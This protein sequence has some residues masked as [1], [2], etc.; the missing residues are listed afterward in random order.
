[1]TF[2]LFHIKSQH[3][4]NVR[5]LTRIVGWLLIIE[6]I[7]MAIPA[8]TSYLYCESDWMPF[9]LTSSGTTLIGLL[10][11]FR[12]KPTSSHTGKREGF[13]LTASVW[14][15]FSLFGMIPFLF[16]SN[17]L[18][19][20]DAFF[21][22]MSGFTTTG[23]SVITG[24]GSMSHGIHLWRAMMQWIGGMG[25][26][27]FT[28]AIIPMLNHAG[29]MQ[30]FNAE[31]TGITHDKIRPRISQT[32]KSL[33]I[34]Y[35]L[36][37][38]TLVLLLWAGP[39]SLFDSVCH[40]FGTISTGGYSSSPEGIGHWHGSVYVKLVLTGFMFLGGVNF[41]LIFKTAHGDFKA[42][43]Q[44]DVFH[45]YVAMI[46]V[47]LTL[48]II[49]IL[50]C[51]AY[52]GWESITIDP[53]FQIVS[54]MTSTGFMVE[55]FSEWG[56]FVLAITFFLMFFGACAGSTSGGAKIDRM[57]YLFR[58]S[59][60][61]IY[62]CLYPN[63]IKS[64]KVNG[65]VA[66]A[67]LV[68]KVIAFLCLYMIL[69]VGGGIMLC[70]LGVPVVDAFFS[71][72]SCISNTGLGAGVTGFGGG[73]ELMPDAAKWILSFLMLTGRLEIFTILLLF[74]PYFWKR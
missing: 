55:D 65:K 22:A 38:L 14:I 28:L 71:A 33:W 70:A 4:V 25:I 17:P 15:V 21:E 9:A 12:S 11:A 30:M 1:M 2:N 43:R 23:A 16:C 49:S 51:G 46:F 6:G 31:V 52:K 32:A 53:I 57:I 26:I 40:A 42:M 44:N 36:L 35:F 5:M 64:V 24:H 37:T 20:S 48:F 7:F 58:N 62:R 63:A 39:M 59:S 56:T 19:I 72:F 10:L 67:E 45:T 47:F 3:L 69:I 27:L 74:T 66:S 54:V 13:L 34:V 29:G 73:Y 50:V 68:N 8:L 41:A 60:N 61:E 18:N